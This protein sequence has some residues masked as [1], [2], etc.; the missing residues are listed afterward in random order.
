MQLARIL[1]PLQHAHPAFMGIFLTDTQ[2]KYQ[3][4]DDLS[5]Y[6]DAHVAPCIHERGLANWMTR[7]GSLLITL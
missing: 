4:G 1:F 5:F 2:P 6:E 7:F 3:L